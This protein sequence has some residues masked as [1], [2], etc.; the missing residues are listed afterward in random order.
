MDLLESSQKL[1]TDLTFSTWERYFFRNENIPSYA[2]CGLVVMQTR[3]YNIIKTIVCPPDNDCLLLLLSC[4]RA[5]TERY[6]CANVLLLEIHDLTLASRCQLQK[7]FR[8]FNA[9]GGGSN[10]QLKSG[11]HDASSC[12]CEVE[13]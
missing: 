12:C 11:C 2:G 1:V 5:K 3:Q 7:R 6:F 4:T 8:N 10:L 9:Y 13:K